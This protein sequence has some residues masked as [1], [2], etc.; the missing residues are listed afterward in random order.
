MRL[1]LVRHGITQH[2]INGLYTGQTDA[3]LTELGQRQALAVAKYL[4]DETFDAI[5][6]SDLQRARH[7]AQA[8]AS[9]HN[10]PVQEDADLREISMGTWEGYTSAE[11]Q[12]RNIDEWKYVRNDSINHAPPGGENFSQ[13][14]ERAGRALQHCREQY[15]DKTVLWAA[16]GGFIEAALCYALK[17]DL[18]YR[19]CFRNGNTSVN[20]LHFKSNYELPEIIRLNDLAHL[21]TINGSSL[22]S[23]S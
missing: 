8:I 12:A 5:F 19:H 13:V 15:T 22:L 4:A 17:L 1:F 16:H 23:A 10:L 7:T 3:P 6:S 21:R 9:Y 11:L 2:N 14:L 18:H 20:E